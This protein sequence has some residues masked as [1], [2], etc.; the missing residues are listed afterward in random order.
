MLCVLLW[1]E[2]G[3]KDADDMLNELGKKFEIKKLGKAS[4]ILGFGIHQGLEGIFVEQSAYDDLKLIPVNQRDNFIFLLV[5]SPLWGIPGKE[6]L[7]QNGDLSFK[8]SKCTP[9]MTG[10]QLVNLL[11]K[12]SVEIDR[13]FP[14]TKNV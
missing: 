7:L 5:S 13:L 3:E 14:F 9:G 2:A 11:A 6:K 8:R 4:H 1:S 12:V 10:G